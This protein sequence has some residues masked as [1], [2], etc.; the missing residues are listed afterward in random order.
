MPW[1]GARGPSDGASGRSAWGDAVVV[2]VE[3]PGGLIA[4]P[5][6]PASSEAAKDRPKKKKVVQ[7]HGQMLKAKA[8]VDL[9]AMRHD[10]A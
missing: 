6:I 2:R 9:V 4:G 7:D 8:V 10:V 5:E 3:I 1:L